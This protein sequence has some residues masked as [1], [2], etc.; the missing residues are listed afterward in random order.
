VLKS[1]E[2]HGIDVVSS[3]E[4]GDRVGSGSAMVRKDLSL[5]GDTGTPGLGYNVRYLQGRIQDVFDRSVCQLIWVGAQWLESAAGVL[6]AQ[7]GVNFRIVAAV[8]SRPE[9]IGQR[10][11]Q[12]QVQPLS[13]LPALFAGGVHGAVMALPEDSGR[14]TEALVAAGAKGILNLTPYTLRVPPDVTVRHLDL[15]GEIMALAV[16]CAGPDEPG[17]EAGSP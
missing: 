12:W 8:D 16:E 11:G 14:A 4:L 5:L 13:E 1:F 15:L 17:S 9:W 3:R 6:A 10:V 2:E 7:T